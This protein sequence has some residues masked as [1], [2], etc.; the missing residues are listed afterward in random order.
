MNTNDENDDLRA[1]LQRAREL[2]EQ[3]E[4]EILVP[5]RR[6]VA[7]LKHDPEASK[8]HNGHKDETN[9]KREYKD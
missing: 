8:K 1:I 5:M 3:A 6:D 2:S 7:M 9:I 4:N